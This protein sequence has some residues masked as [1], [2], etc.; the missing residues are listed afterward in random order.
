MKERSI[1]N[2]NIIKKALKLPF[3][4]YKKFLLVTFLFFIA[5]LVQEYLLILEIN[6]IS[7]LYFI[8]TIILSFLI[9]GINVIIIYDAI[10]YNHGLPN[11]SPK[12]SIMVGIEDFILESYYLMLSLVVSLICI[13]PTGI[14]NN[15]RQLDEFYHETFYRLQDETI[16]EFIGNIPVSILNNLDKTLPLAITIFTFIVIIILSFCTLNKID[17]KNNKDC[18]YI[19]T[20]NPFN[21]IR[22]IKK[23]GL[24]NYFIFIIMITVITIILAKVVHRLN[25]ILY[26]GSLTSAFLE[27]FTLFFFLASFHYLYE[28]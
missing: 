5:E 2:I 4:K 7:F 27:A 14:Y 25:Y 1:K 26:F 3:I 22:I 13:I 23:I 20:F 19:D 24:E 10:G 21:T 9:L 8:S 16:I 28:S 18:K 17:H 15:F 11:I 6:E 12:K